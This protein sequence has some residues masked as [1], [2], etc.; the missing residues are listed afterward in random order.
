MTTFRVAQRRRFTTV[1]NSTIEDASL[2]FRARGVLVWLLSKPD[3]WSASSDAICRQGTEGRD[4]IRNT[5]R[6]LETAGYIRREKIR[7]ADGT[8]TS[9][10]TVY[11]CGVPSTTDSQASASQPP[12]G[13]AV[14]QELRAKTDTKRD[15]SSS[16]DDG[17]FDSIFDAFW[18]QYPRKTGKPAA[19]KALK[20]VASQ[21]GAIAT[22]LAKWVEFWNADR[23]EQ[24]FIPHPATW[25]NQR[26]WEDDPPPTATVTFGPAELAIKMVEWFKGRFDSVTWESLLPTITTLQKWGFGPGEIAVRMAAMSRHNLAGLSDPHLV[27]R[28]S[29]FA[30]FQGDPKAFGDEG[31]N[32]V[33]AMERAYQNQRWSNQ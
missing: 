10:C 13:Q 31:V 17:V 11:E 3:D 12:E 5:L 8:F 18:K 30:R 33:T 16:G 7:L 19:K 20:P 9:T 6:E 1:S 21:P 32:Y 27:A 28:L 29:G 25:L 15:S 26:R 14:I 24:R 23:T 2:S 4:A 22:G